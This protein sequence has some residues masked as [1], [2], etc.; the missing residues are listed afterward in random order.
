M[1]AV[2]VTKTDQPHPP[3]PGGGGGQEGGGGQGEG[4]G[5]R[6]HYFV[7][8]CSFFHHLS[9]K[10]SNAEQPSCFLFAAPGGFIDF[11]A[12]RCIYIDSSQ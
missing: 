2:S 11:T 8:I 5:V 1:P 12:G 9:Y 6:L 4:Q 10:H 3:W 7:S